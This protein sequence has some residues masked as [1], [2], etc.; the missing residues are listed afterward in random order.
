M[1]SDDTISLIHLP[2][3]SSKNCDLPFANNDR[4][5]ANY[6]I[7]SVCPLVMQLNDLFVSEMPH[8]SLSFLRVE[9]GSYT[10]ILIL[11]SVARDH[12][13]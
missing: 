2:R 9:I 6:S 11:T 1:L 4:F 5:K 13:K 10:N 3:R 7:D 12:D 8:V